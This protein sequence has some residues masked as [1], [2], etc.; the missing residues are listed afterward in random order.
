LQQPSVAIVILNYNG[1]NY[2]E[3]FLPSVM[4]ST[5]QNKKIIVADNASTDDSIIFLQQHFPSVEILLNTK[6]DALPVVITGH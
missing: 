3:R 2:L 6:N 1:R 5:Y 4:R